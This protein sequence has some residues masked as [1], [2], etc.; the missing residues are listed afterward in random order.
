[1]GR[2]P[3]REIP[4]PLKNNA[5]FL[6]GTVV[7]MFE[8]LRKINVRFFSGHCNGIFEDLYWEILILKKN[9]SNFFQGTVPAMV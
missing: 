4:G 7:A 2:R 9:M 6:G 5:Q 1:M 3:V 8:G